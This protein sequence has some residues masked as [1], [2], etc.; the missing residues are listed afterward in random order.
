MSTCINI[1]QL[2]FQIFTWFNHISNILG[3]C[4]LNFIL[5]NCKPLEILLSTDITQSMR[6]GSESWTW[7]NNS[8]LIWKMIVDEIEEVRKSNC[9][10]MFFK[11]GPFMPVTLLKRDSTQVFSYEYCKVFKNS[12]FYRTPL[13]AAFGYSNQSKISQEI[14]ASKFQGQHAVPF[15]ICRYE[16]LCPATKTKIHSGYFPRNF[17]KF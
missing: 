13:V 8:V 17:A 16:G 1:L 5:R 2:I 12:V 6:N 3:A 9:S 10:Q 7:S 15:N 11:K 14:T 4:K